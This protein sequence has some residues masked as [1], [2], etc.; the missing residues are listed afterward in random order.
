MSRASA[1]P[2]YIWRRM[3]LRLTII[4]LIRSATTSASST[5]PSRW[6][7]LLSRVAFLRYSS[8]FSE[9]TR[10]MLADEVESAQW[11]E[12]VC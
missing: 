3:L 7:I 6:T 10:S 12:E 2:S 5:R 8:R 4:I 1:R 11:R 9:G